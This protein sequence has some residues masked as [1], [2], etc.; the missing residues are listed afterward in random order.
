MHVLHATIC[1]YQRSPGGIF[2][3]QTDVAQSTGQCQHQEVGALEKSPAGYI[4]IYSIYMSVH[5]FKKKKK[6]KKKLHLRYITTMGLCLFEDITTKC[7]KTQHVFA[8][9]LE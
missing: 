9:R 1:Y 5:M 2:S 6:K 4:H 7:N 3:M 8:K